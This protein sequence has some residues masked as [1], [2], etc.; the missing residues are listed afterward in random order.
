MC[1][2]FICAVGGEDGGFSACVCV[3][4]CVEKM[5]RVLRRQVAITVSS[6]P[7]LS[8]S[9][10]QACGV[11]G[12][13]DP[14]RPIAEPSASGILDGVKSKP[15]VANAKGISMLWVLGSMR[16]TNGGFPNSMLKAEWIAKMLSGPRIHL[17]Q[18]KSVA[19]LNT[20]K[21]DEEKPRE[22]AS[23]SSMQ[24][25]SLED[26]QH[27]EIVGPTVERDMS[28]VADELRKAYLEMREAIQKFTKALL[29]VGAVHLMWGGMMFR[30]MDSPLSHAL[31]TQV[32]VSAFIMFGLA[33]YSKQTLKPIEFLMKLEER[34]RLRIITLSLQVTKTIGSFFQRGYGVGL[35]LLFG[36]TAH[37]LAC[38]KF[39]F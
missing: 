10:N 35:V 9:S 30:V 29:A 39:F 15:N 23:P 27:E 8:R 11:F 37:L 28:P 1:D 22:P 12:P 7:L 31:L 3:C 36:L 13:H 24:P 26:F 25:K 34:S 21:E 19:Y 4:V 2:S 32:S 18:S 33:Y 6:P 17:I 20:A 5:L 16:N 14:H 38:L